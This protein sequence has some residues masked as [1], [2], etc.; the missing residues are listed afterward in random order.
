[1]SDIQMIDL[2]QDDQLEKLAKELFEDEKKEKS[3]ADIMHGDEQDR[4]TG[5]K[6]K[7]ARWNPVVLGLLVIALLGVTGSF[8]CYGMYRSEKKI[9]KAN[10]EAL[11]AS[12]QA[13]SEKDEQLAAIYESRYEEGYNQG[14]LSGADEQL[15]FL[16]ENIRA[17]AE[18]KGVLQA[19]RDLY[20]ECVVFY[21]TA[22][23]VFRD[24][25]ANLGLHNLQADRFVWDE[26]GFVDYLENGEKV[27]H[28]GIDV[29]KYNQKIDWNKVAES[30]IEFAFVRVGFR[31]YGSG[32]IVLDEMF[33]SHVRG[34]K[35]AGL[36]VG[37]YFFTQAVTTKEAEE[38]AQ[39]ILDQIRLTD[40]TVDFPIVFDVE[41]VNVNTARAENLSVE[42]RT[43]IT[44]AFCEKIKEAGYTPMIYGNIK[45][46]MNMLDMSML[47]DYKKW[48]AYYDSSLY[49]P[50]EISGWQFSDKGKVNGID[51]EVDIN[52]WFDQSMFE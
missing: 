4:K 5:K 25:D 45:C 49:F 20:P 40:I 14:M 24:I 43:A 28:R 29:S 46:F 15:N 33:K 13:V 8:Y 19:L 16:K 3:H 12:S 26:D 36:K 51:G 2:D 21:D 52:I 18:E 7:K 42:D 6:M 23:Y 27:S 31:G 30:G 37:V 34:A 10:G 1:M 48:F 9:N 22:G 11:A 38:E 41:K 32:D 47:K 17:T 35:S 50:Y 44:I 39:F